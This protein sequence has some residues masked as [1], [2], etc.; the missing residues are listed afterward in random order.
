M[1]PLSRGPY[2]RGLDRD[3]RPIAPA[4]SE[5][6]ERT[7]AGLETGLSA[8]RLARPARTS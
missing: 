3:L 7:S 8:R 2:V 1:D 4:P 6:R 5:Q